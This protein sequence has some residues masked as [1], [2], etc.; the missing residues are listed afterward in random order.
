MA[1]AI[2]EVP[3]SEQPRPGPLSSDELAAFKRDGFVAVARPV[4]PAPAIDQVLRIMD[5]RVFG[6]RRPIPGYVHDHGKPFGLDD[7]PPLAPNV[8]FCTDLAPQLMRSRAYATAKAVAEQL[9]GGPVRY[10]FDQS[11]YKPPHSPA[12]TEWHTDLGYKRYPDTAP[13]SVNFWIALQDTTSDMGAMRY[14]PGSQQRV[15]EHDRQ[16]HVIIARDVPED[17][18]VTCPLPKGGFTIHALRT[19]HGSNGNSTDHP[20]GSWII[21]FTRDERGAVRKFAD[22]RVHL[23]RF[24]RKNG[25]RL[26]PRFGPALNRIER[27]LA[28]RGIKV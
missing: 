28:D 21:H 5:E 18:A 19:I 17:D 1:V 13:D 9:L 22:D 27:F 23:D 10:E 16:G 8:I 14:I 26:S 12:K 6:A 7:G 11:I 2:E 24:I 15:V 20:R 4:I 3:V 25:M